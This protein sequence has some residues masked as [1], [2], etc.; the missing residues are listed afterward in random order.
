MGDWPSQMQAACWA[1]F[2][3]L[4]HICALIP[5]EPAFNENK[6]SEALR[7]VRTLSV[8][9]LCRCCSVSRFSAICTQHLG[10]HFS[11]LMLS[12]LSSYHVP[13]FSQ[14][15]LFPKSTTSSLNNQVQRNHI[16]SSC[17]AT[18]TMQPQTRCTVNGE[19][20]W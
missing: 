12:L 4:W 11:S 17:G 10:L 9:Y 1:A 7:L 8:F 5:T 2:P 18:S 20:T 3:C 13:S 15:L 14:T 6:V 16:Q 19:P